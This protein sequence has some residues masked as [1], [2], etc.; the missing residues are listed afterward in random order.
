MKQSFLS[1]VALAPFVSAAIYDNVADI[2]SLD[3]DYVIIGGTHP[4]GG[5]LSRHTEPPHPDFDYF[6]QP[7]PLATLSV[8]A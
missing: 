1:L 8:T 6:H 7:E 4:V 2:D 5:F 3:V